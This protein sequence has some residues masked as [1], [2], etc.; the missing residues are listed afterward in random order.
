ME[1]VCVSETSVNFYQDIW[2]QISEN[3][4]LYVEDDLRELKVKR[5]R[6]KANKERQ[7]CGLKED[8]VLRRPWS[9]RVST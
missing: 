4:F 9:E 2:S 3:I 7:A 6:Q 8:K 1:L 5:W